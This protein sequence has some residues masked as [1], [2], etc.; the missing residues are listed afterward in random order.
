MACNN[1]NNGTI[2]CVAGDVLEVY[3]TLE[4]IDAEQIEEVIF[5]CS[6]R[7]LEVSCHFIDD[8]GGYAMR[9]DSVETALLT[10]GISDYDLTVKF[11][12]GNYFTA[13][14]NNA[15]QILP[16]GNKLSGVDYGE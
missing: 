16:K 10:S 1:K 14:Y 6:E 9:L 2:S 11:V 5:S 4:N 8:E 15:F 3:F 13:M 7:S 12:D